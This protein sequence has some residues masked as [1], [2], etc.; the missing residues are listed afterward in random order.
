MKFEVITKYYPEIDDMMDFSAKAVGYKMDPKVE[1]II[2]REYMEQIRRERGS[3]Y[4]ED[5]LDELY[6]FDGFAYRGEDGK[7]Y[8]VVFVYDGEQM[9]PF[10]WQQLIEPEPKTYRDLAE[11]DEGTNLG[12]CKPYVSADGNH[13]LILHDGEV[14]SIFSPTVRAYRWNGSLTEEVM[15]AFAREV[16]PNYDEYQGWTDLHIA[17]ESMRETGCWHCPWRDNCDAMGEEVEA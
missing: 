11:E 2:D 5:K 17:L 1:R 6:D 12:W 14:E 16:N 7:A 9:R 4:V 3:R 8:A 13:V 10:C 15:A